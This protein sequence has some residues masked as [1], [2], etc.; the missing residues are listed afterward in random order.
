MGILW[1]DL[2]P[3]KTHIF[4]SVRDPNVHCSLLNLSGSNIKLWKFVLTI[5][6]ATLTYFNWRPPAP[7]W[8]LPQPLNIYDPPSQKQST[9]LSLLS[10][11]QTVSSKI[12]PPA[13][14]PFTFNTFINS[15]LYAFRIL[16]N[17]WIYI[18]STNPIRISYHQ[19]IDINEQCKQQWRK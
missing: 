6:E 10:T 18:S 12:C 3:L 5:V 11:W 19:R 16:H 9:R 17:T 14:K 4:F 15:T 2:S 13:T 8:A 1:S 7:L